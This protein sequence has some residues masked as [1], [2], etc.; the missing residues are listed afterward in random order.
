MKKDSVEGNKH[1]FQ[2]MKVS[3]TMSIMS[4]EISSALRFVCHENP[5]DKR[6]STAWFISV[7]RQWFDLM[8]NRKLSLALSKL[9]DEKFKEAIDFLNAVIV[10]FK[11]LTV[12]DKGHWKPFQAAVILSTLTV[13]D[14][15]QY[16][17]NDCNFQFFLTSCLTQDCLENLFSAVRRKNV[18]PN[19]VQFKNNL[20]LISFPNL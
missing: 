4:H 11:D 3:N 8:I 18:V 20:K 14:L 7:V 16:L 15:L 12:G 2:K 1:H 5:K 6:P 13:I 10:L 9:K 19:A 17:I